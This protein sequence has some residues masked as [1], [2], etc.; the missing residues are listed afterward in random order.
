[1]ATQNNF[2]L[3]QKRLTAWGRWYHQVVTLGLDYSHQSLLG[4]IVAEKG[5]VIT[6]TAKQLAPP[7]S[8]AEEVDELLEYLAAQTP[9]GEG[10]A[11]WVRITRIHY[12]LAEKN[13]TEKVQA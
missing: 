3:T 10:H 2:F 13:Y 11:D 8:E 4:R 7:N 12:T 9:Q 1:M 5:F 6:S